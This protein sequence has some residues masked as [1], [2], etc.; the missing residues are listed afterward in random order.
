MVA[1]PDWRA[2]EECESK[3]IQVIANMIE[4]LPYVH[5]I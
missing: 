4:L 3:A 1:E 5:I 2:I